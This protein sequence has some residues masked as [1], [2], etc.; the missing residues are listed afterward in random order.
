MEPLDWVH[1]QPTQVFS[2]LHE[3][4]GLNDEERRQVDQRRG[5]ARGRVKR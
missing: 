4:A 1:L 3:M 2:D 5:Q